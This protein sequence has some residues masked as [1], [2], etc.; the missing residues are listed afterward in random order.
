MAQRSFKR[1]TITWLAAVVGVAAGGLA[2]NIRHDP[3]G[4]LAALSL[5]PLKANA[6][7]LWSAGMGLYP[8]RAGNREGKALNAIWYKPQVAVFGSSNVWS[9]VDP[10]RPSLRQPDGRFAYNFGLPGISMF[11]LA[12]AVHH[13]VALGHM[14]R[15]VAGLEFFM[16]AGNR[17]FPGALDTM[18]LAYQPQYRDRIFSYVSR[19]LLSMDALSKSIPSVFREIVP[20]AIAAEA[21]APQAID[22]ERLREMIHRADREQTTALYRPDLPFLFANKDGETTFDALRSTI[23]L[24]QRERIALDLYLTPHHARAYELIRA[25]GLWPKYRAWLRELAT[26]ADTTGACILDFGSY[27]DLTTDTTAATVANAV[28][29]THPDSIHMNTELAS[30]VI[31]GLG[32]GACSHPDGVALSGKSIDGYLGEIEARR[33]RFVR[34]H[35]AFAADVAAFA[36]TLPHRP[37]VLNAI[38]P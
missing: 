10:R 37:E 29:R 17:P 13:T 19:H 24:V 1:F 18:P 38:R 27:S 16:F 14:R 25:I 15:A 12:A 8:M 3:S 4:V 36:R 7:D 30:R 5:K 11:E 6:S 2:L 23:A 32:T 22:D 34:D 21:A 20:A 35:P 28:F 9:Y 26:I 31:D 33:E